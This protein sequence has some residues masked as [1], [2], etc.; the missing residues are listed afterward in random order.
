M[1]YMNE[2]KTTSIS[3]RMPGSGPSGGTLVS[4]CGTCEEGRADHR[5]MHHLR[6]KLI[7]NKV[8]YGKK[9]KQSRTYGN[10]MKL[11]VTLG[12][13]YPHS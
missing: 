2:R 3:Q 7:K 10:W 4:C 6:Y 11:L 13:P 9:R 5:S 8:K 1:I 12:K